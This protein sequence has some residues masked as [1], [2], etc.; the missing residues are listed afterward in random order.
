VAMHHASV[1]MSGA[2]AFQANLSDTLVPR[3]SFVATLVTSDTP[4]HGV[5]LVDY[6]IKP[7][8]Q[9]VVRR[10]ANSAYDWVATHLP[11]VW[12]SLVAGCRT[13]AHHVDRI[14][15]EVWRV[16]EQAFTEFCH[17]LSQLLG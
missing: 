15:A 12:E 6:A 16:G 13:L 3:D 10:V 11:P 9:A 8:V 14:L 1:V 2:G 4:S 17:W 7:A 5:S